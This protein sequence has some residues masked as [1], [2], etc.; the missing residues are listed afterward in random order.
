MKKKNTPLIVSIIAASILISGSLIFLGT[1]LKARSMATKDNPNE[2]LS[3]SIRKGIETYVQEKQ[4]EATQPQV[5]SGDYTDDDPV[6]GD[7]DAPVT[8]VE[9]SDFE[10][11]FCRRFFND[12]LPTLKEKYID[13]GKVKFVYRDF[14]LSFHKDA[15]PAALAANCA[16][17]QG[18]DET[19][20][21]YH[22][23]IFNGENKLGQ[24]TVDIPEESLKAYALQL[25]LNT[26]RFNE[27]LSSQKYADEVQKDFADGQSVGVRGTPAFLV[28]GQMVSGAQPFSAFEQIIEA[29]LQ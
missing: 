10:C 8:I 19:F 22:D 15:L 23:L 7:K 14:P 2:D 21:A 18:N 9:W 20:F 1:Q 28:N 13:T 24:G 3:A 5:V 17:E 29:E 27:C 12:T 4:A 16:R 26:D 11:P 6:M 25:G